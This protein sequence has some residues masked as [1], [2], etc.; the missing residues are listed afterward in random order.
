MIKFRYKRKEPNNNVEK[1]SDKDAKSDAGGKRLNTVKK[2]TSA[3]TTATVTSATLKIK[4]I[5]NET[6]LSQNIR[7]D[8][9]ECIRAVVVS[10]VALSPYFYLLISIS[11]SLSSPL[12]AH[13]RER[14]RQYNILR[15]Y[16]YYSIMVCAVKKLIMLRF[17]QFIVL[18]FI[19]LFLFQ[20]ICDKIVFDELI[21]W[22][23]FS[24]LFFYFPNSP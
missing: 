21:I 1:N 9:L 24:F 14:L 18:F 2:T 10:S 20:S 13:M 11:L 8:Y 5:K 6:S 19:A 4:D 7:E 3:T 23:Y 15:K 16:I 22:I 17:Y 12:T